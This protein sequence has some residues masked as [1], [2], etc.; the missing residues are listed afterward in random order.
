[1]LKENGVD[2]C[3]LF[4]S[5]SSSLGIIGKDLMEEKIPTVGVAMIVRN[6]A[7]CIAQAIESVRYIAR[8]VVVIDTGSTD[9][10]AVI[11]TRQGAE[12]Y[13]FSWTN[14][15]SEARNY[16][17]RHMRTDWILALDADE[18]IDEESFHKEFALLM[19]ASTGGVQTC[20]VNTLSQDGSTSHS[21]FYTRLFRRDVRIRYSGAIHEQIADS[22]RS[23]GYSIAES[24]ILIRHHGYAD[25]QPEKVERNARM[26]RSALEEHPND[27][28]TQYHLGLTEFA[29]GN[30]SESKRLLTP[31]LDSPDLSPE[32]REFVAIRCAQA[33]LA[34]D[35][36]LGTERLLNFSSSDIHREGLR[37]FILG[38]AMSMQQDFS[39]AI[40]YLTSA[41][42]VQSQLID[43]VSRNNIVEKLREMVA[44]SEERYDFVRSSP[45]DIW[46]GVFR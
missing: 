43:Q 23:A 20:I 28:W 44:A 19:N 36:L 3:T 33:A 22:I 31:L 2:M 46:L 9:N 39:R 16:A 25:V 14:D 10:T 26:L 11:A 24:A 6:A 12:V 34:E 40:L 21:H 30:L 45:D 27:A 4:S 35:D 41:A 32:Q 42:T 17:L 7:H 37:L 15:F 8:Q 29:G 5:C 1:M 38:A 13:F 18:T